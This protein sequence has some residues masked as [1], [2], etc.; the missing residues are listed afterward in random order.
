VRTGKFREADL[1]GGA[2]PDLVLDSVAD[3]PARFPW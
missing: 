1:E 2:R 3:L